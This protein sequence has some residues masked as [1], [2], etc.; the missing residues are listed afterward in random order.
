M[1]QPRA[2]PADADFVEHRDG[3]NVERHL[4]R[5][6][7]RHRALEGQIEI[8][9]HIAAVARRPVVDQRF[10]MR[11]P[12]LE[13][14]AV[15][16]R[17]ERRAGRAQRLRHVD[18][19]GAALVEII[20]RADARAHFAALIVDRDD[21]DRN[22]RAERMRALARK[23]F[24][25]PLQIGVDGEPVH[26]LVRL[27]GDHLL[28]GMRRQHRHVF[29]RVRH[30][31]RLGARASSR[32]TD[33]GG[34]IAIEHA[35]A[36]GPRGFRITIR[37]AHFRRLRQRDQQRGFGQ[38]TAAAAPCRNRQAKP[39]GSLPGFRHRAQA[40]DITREFASLLSARS[41]SMARVIWR[42]LAPMLRCWRGSSRRATCMVMVE[43]PETMCPLVTNCQAA[44]ASA[45]GSTP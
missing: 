23:L 38:A 9:R 26:A 24:Q 30:R 36:R 42:N 29:A 1:R 8:L 10:R 35:V 22:L 39:R 45:S 14:H 37:P 40:S 15:D 2:Q 13:G 32:A 31:L 7:H 4:Q 44:R 21:G 3:R 16:E 33:A 43:P 34:D 11:Q 28:G 25:S 20:G 41:S 19:A 17:L 18:L 6:A 12:V 5:A 27:G